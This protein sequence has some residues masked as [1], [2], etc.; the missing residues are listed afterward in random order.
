MISYFRQQNERGTHYGKDTIET[1]INTLETSPIVYWKKDRTF[2]IEVIPKEIDE[3]K[4][5]NLNHLK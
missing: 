2:N 1:S 5:N 4:K 3:K